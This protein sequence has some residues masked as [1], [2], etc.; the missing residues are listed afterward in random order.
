MVPIYHYFIH[1]EEAS[2]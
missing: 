2:Q 1:E